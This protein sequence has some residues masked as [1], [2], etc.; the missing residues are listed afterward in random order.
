MEAID[1]WETHPAIAGFLSYM[2]P[3]IHTLPDLEMAKKY[4]KDLPQECDR[5]LIEFPSFITGNPFPLGEIQITYN[6]NL[7]TQEEA[8]E[9]LESMTEIL[10]EERARASEYSSTP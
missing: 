10:R 2:N 9:W 8:K 3:D 1:I 5:M 7:H 4:A 6:R